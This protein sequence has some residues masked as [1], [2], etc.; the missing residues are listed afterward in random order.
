M[1]YSGKTAFG[2]YKRM[3]SPKPVNENGGQI[4]CLYHTDKYTVKLSS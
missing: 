2:M 3:F 1:L 4:I